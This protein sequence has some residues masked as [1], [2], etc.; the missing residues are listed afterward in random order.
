MIPSKSEYST[1]W[2]STST[3]KRFSFGS[4]EG[5]FGTAHDNRTPFQAEIIM[6]PARA[7]LL[8]DEDPRSRRALLAERLGRAAGCPFGAVSIEGIGGHRSFHV[9]V[10]VMSARAIG[11]ATISFGLVSIPV[12]LY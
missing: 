8:H 10:F 7:M 5:P 4:N 6:K 9:T 11:S 3:A 1:G 2:S 12:K